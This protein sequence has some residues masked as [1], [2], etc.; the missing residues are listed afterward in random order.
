[1]GGGVP[2]LSKDLVTPWEWWYTIKEPSRKYKAAFNHVVNLAVQSFHSVQWWSSISNVF[3]HPHLEISPERAAFMIH[4]LLILQMILKTY[5]ITSCIWKLDC[6]SNRKHQVK[7]PDQSVSLPSQTKHLREFKN[8]EGLFGLL[9][10]LWSRTDQP[11]CFGPVA[12]V[13]DG[14]WL[15]KSMQLTSWQL[16]SKKDPEEESV[17]HSSLRQHIIHQPETPVGSMFYGSFTAS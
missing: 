4:F 2:G 15:R 14:G 11:C 13:G 17:F 9:C 7:R 1:M 16:G 6:M 5:Q 12:G 8:K 3:K 10:W